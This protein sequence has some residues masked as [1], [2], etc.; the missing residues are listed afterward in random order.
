MFIAIDVETANWSYSSIC[1]IGYVFFAEDGS[2]IPYQTYINPEEHFSSFHTGIHSITAKDVESALTFPQFHAH[3]SSQVSGKI[4]VCHTAF[5][6]AAFVAACAKYELP[7]FPC[8]WLD[9]AK[10]VR[11]AWP[12]Q[13]AKSGYGLHNVAQHLGIEYT[14]HVA[15]EDARV[16]GEIVLR[17]LKDSGTPLN[18][19]L[20]RVDRPIVS[21]I[22]LEGNPDGALYGETLV[23]TGALS[24]PR[25]QAADMAAAAGC[26]VASNVTKKTTI[27]VVGDQDIQRLAGHTKSS[28][29]RKAEKLLEKGHRLQIICESDFVRLI[30]M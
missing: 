8:T 10:I 21:R 29:H 19:W 12:E 17:A 1:Q 11:R 20:Q 22:A 16:A 30:A 25:R 2:Q 7:P 5:D 26:K 15:V 9:S 3:L 14:P 18:D 27:L 23:F 24:M 6:R 13:F 4:V 28:K